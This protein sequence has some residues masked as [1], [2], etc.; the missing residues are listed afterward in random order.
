M[1][2]DVDVCFVSCAS[3]GPCILNICKILRL[4]YVLNF[5]ISTWI[6]TAHIYWPLTMWQVV[7]ERIYMSL[8]PES[9][10][11]TACPSHRRVAELEFEPGAPSPSPNS[12]PLALKHL[13]H[14]QLCSQNVV[15]AKHTE[16]VVGPEPLCFLFSRRS[17]HIMQ[18]R[19]FWYK[20]WI[21]FPTLS[22]VLWLCL[23][24]FCCFICHVVVF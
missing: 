12:P 16:M 10:V 6:L 14:K 4:N 5:K 18:I 15:S 1:N 7:T 8:I 17:S 20:L 23:W 22:F 3:H 19:V 2:N 21:Y 24:C 13:H 11:G 9:T